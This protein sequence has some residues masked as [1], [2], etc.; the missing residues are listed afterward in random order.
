[1]ADVDKLEDMRALEV[2]LLLVFWSRVCL[3][4]E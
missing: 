3:L 4:L 1:M 2:L